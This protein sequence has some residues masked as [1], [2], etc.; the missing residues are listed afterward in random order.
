MNAIIFDMDGVIFDSESVWK[1]AFNEANKKFNLNLTENYRQSTCGQNET[2]VRK[3]LKRTYLN[4]D[5]DA[6][7]DYMCQFYKDYISKQGIPLKTGFLELVEYL[8]QTNHKIALATGSDKQYVQIMFKH[9]HLN[10]HKI[11]DFIITGDEVKN[12]KPDPE[13][14]IKASNGIK[15][16]SANCIVLE[17]SLNGIKSAFVAGCKPIMVVDIIKP[18]AYAK[19]HAIKICNSLKEVLNYFLE[20]K[21]W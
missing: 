8:K 6:Y 15:E 13:I 3:D 18:N 2:D 10:I 19:S 21:I 16:Q 14:Y 9:A 4:L 11:F 20:N 12:G 17:D 1:L 7:R 5:V